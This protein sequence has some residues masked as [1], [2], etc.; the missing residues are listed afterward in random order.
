MFPACHGSSGFA[1]SHHP[2]VSHVASNVI[3]LDNLKPICP[4]FLAVS[5]PWK[6]YWMWILGVRRWHND[7]RF[8]WLQ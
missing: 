4:Q 6:L 5:Y 3:Y 2:K 7:L 8:I 1:Y